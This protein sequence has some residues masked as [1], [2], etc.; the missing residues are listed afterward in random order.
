MAATTLHSLMIDELRDLYHAEQQLVKAL[1]KIAEAVTADELREALEHHLS[2]TEQHVSRLE[3][4][5]DLL[6]EP[7][8]AKP[9]AGMQGILKEGSSL[10]KETKK[11]A[12]RDAGIIGGG[13]RVEHY[14]V[15]AYGTVLAWARD[16]GKDDVA[17]LLQATLDEEKAA[18]QKL[19]ELAEGC[20]NEAAMNGDASE[21]DEGSGETRSDSGDK[22]QPRQAKM[23]ATGNGRA[24]TS[25]K[26]RAAR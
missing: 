7:A 4:I 18:D 1:P 20:L 17:E 8:K 10:I 14:E 15:A 9:C 24:G 21:S 19:S 11:G 5:F 22:R 6:E 3:K 16:M 26:T 2:E 13:Q 23:A 12:A 25:G